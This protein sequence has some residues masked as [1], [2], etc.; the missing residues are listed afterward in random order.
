MG[1]IGQ[2]QSGHMANRGVETHFIAV[3][4]EEIYCSGL[5]DLRCVQERW[6]PCMERG[7]LRLKFF[8]S[9]R[10]REETVAS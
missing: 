4:D 6:Y 5:H 7:A 3:G 8:Q 9:Q 2:L 1:D 10:L